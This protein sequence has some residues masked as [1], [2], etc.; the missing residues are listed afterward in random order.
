VKT[1]TLDDLVVSYKVVVFLQTLEE[2][3]RLSKNFKKGEKL[4]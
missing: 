4:T 2:T 3:T 1:T